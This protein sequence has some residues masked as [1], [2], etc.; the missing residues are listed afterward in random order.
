[1]TG[2]TMTDVGDAADVDV[3]VVGAGPA[4]SATARRLALRGRTVALI[5][6]TQFD[7]PRV[8]E[9]LAPDVQPLLLNLGVWD[10]FLSLR[11]APSHGTRAFWGDK[12]PLVHSHL[13]SPWGCGWHVERCAFDR[14]L[15]E[16][17]ERVGATLFCDTTCVGCRETSDG[18]T[19]ALQQGGG[20]HAAPARPLRA[21]VVI[22]AT[23]RVARL[24]RWVGASRI[25]LDHLVSIAT[26][27]DRIETESNGHVLVESAA[28]G[29]W[30][31]APA[32]DGQM[33]AMLMTDADLCGRAE[34]S[35]P[36]AWQARLL[37]TEATRCRLTSGTRTWG[38]RVFCALSQRLQRKSWRLPWLAVGDAAL[39]VDPISGSGV[40]RALSTAR[41]AAEAAVA[42]LE[43]QTRAVE[44]YESDRDRECTTYLCERAA[45]YGIEQ[46]WQQSPFWQRRLAAAARTG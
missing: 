5:E 25:L 14:M 46:R 42:L 16:A 19:L 32:A 8:G 12:M 7:T 35:S 1:M 9:S 33:M 17:A 36:P 24:A 41:A 29:W 34:L 44:D 39:S 4:G 26:V 28:D 3:A 21:R 23:G 38:P 43:G 2:T 30:Y 27:F 18:W 20:T 40:V 37:A 22:D 15:A 31:S 11:P 6:R 10:A 13:I 45:Y